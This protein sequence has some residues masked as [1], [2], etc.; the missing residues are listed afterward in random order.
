[1]FGIEGAMMKMLSDDDLSLAEM[2]DEELRVRTHCLTC[3]ARHKRRRITLWFRAAAPYLPTS[4]GYA[5]SVRNGTNPS[6]STSSSRISVASP[7]RPWSRPPS[8]ASSS[9]RT[10][11]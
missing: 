11:A 4:F 7:S 8:F 5:I 1:M 3:P 9:S 2:T 10:A 6:V